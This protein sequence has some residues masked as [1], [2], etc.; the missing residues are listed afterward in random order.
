MAELQPVVIPILMMSSG[1]YNQDPYRQPLRESA[2][3]AGLS[4]RIVVY[5]RCMEFFE[6]RGAAVLRTAT[7]CFV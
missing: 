3:G 2:R 7:R 5:G 1:T 6:P 4:M